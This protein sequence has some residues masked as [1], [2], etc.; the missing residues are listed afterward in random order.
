MTEQNGQVQPTEQN[1]ITWSPSAFRALRTALKRPGLVTLHLWSEM[2]ELSVTLDMSGLATLALTGRLVNKV[3]I[4]KKQAVQDAGKRMDK[5]P[6][7]PESWLDMTNRILEH[8]DYILAAVIIEP[9]YYMMD[10]LKQFPGG[11]PDDGLCILDFDPDMRRAIIKATEVGDEELN[12]FRT[13]PVGYAIAL[14]EQRAREI[15]EQL[16]S[17]AGDAVVD[18]T[19]VRPSDMV[20]G[21]GTREG[22]SEGSRK[23]SKKEQAEPATI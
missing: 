11:Q 1:D 14:S 16:N 3:Y 2:P 21:E 6:E 23:R 13:D 5:E 22:N 4:S 12:N 15:A 7:N 10:E 8:D 17:A 9:K 20:E 19:E 18:S